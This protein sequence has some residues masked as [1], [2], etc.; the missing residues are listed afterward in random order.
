MNA[1]ATAPRGC[2]ESAA[3]GAP[4]ARLVVIPE[5]P[6]ALAEIAGA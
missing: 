5:L 4:P 2:R 1:Y 3:L 6:A